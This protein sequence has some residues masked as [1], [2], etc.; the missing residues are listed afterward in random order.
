MAID[1]STGKIAACDSEEVY[2]YRPYGRE[3][4]ALRVN[5][6]PPPVF[7]KS[8]TKSQWSLQC[9]L[10]NQDENS[11]VLALSWGS[12]EEL[13]VGS[14]S[15]R[16][17]QTAD[18]VTMIW[19]RQLSRPAKFAQFSPDANLIASTGLYDRL[20]K[21]WRRQSF[22]ADDTRFD[23]TYLL[24]PKT[25]TSVHWRK[26]QDREQSAD[27]VLY[28]L[29]ADY[30]VRI[31]ATTAPH[32]LQV[33]QLWAEIDM[34]ESVQPRQIQSTSQLNERYAF[35]IDSH[36]FAF[37]TERAMQAASDGN[38]EENHALEHLME[39]AKRNPEVCVVLDGRGN[40]SAWGLESIGCKTKTPAIKFN[41]AH[42][43]NFSLSKLNTGE[44][45]LQFLNFCSKELHSTF[46]LLVHHFDGRIEWLE[47]RV[48]ELFDP[49]PRRNR[50]QSKALWTGHD[51]SVKKIVRNR[52]GTA[53]LS[54]TN[55]NEG[56]LWKQKMSR[57]AMTLTRYSSLSCSEHIHRTCL[58]DEGDFVVNLHHHSVSVWDMRASVATQ[59]A[60]ANFEVEGK[61]LCLL[62]LREPD[63]LSSSFYVAVITSRMR[64]IVW[65]IQLSS[66]NHWDARSEKRSDT[67]I[68]QFCSFDLKVQ[69]DLQFVLPVDPAGSPSVSSSFLDTFA[70]DT[71][72]SYTNSGV[73]CAWAAVIEV[74][75]PFVN[76]VVT[77]R[78]E[79]GI[80]NPSLASGSS[81]RKTAIIDATR[82]GLTI[83]DASSGQLEYD[84]HYGVQDLIQDLDWSSTPDEQSILAVGFPHK[85]VILSQMRFDYINTGPAWAPI[86]QIFI[87]ESTPHPIG[88]S[89]WL[90]NGNLVIGSGNQLYVYDQNVSISDEFITDLSIPVHTHRSMTLFDLVT[91]L[92]GPLPVF[93]PQ[94]LAQCMLAGRLVQ[95]Q[96]I[97]IGLHKALKFFS[98]GDE[99]DSFVSLPIDSFFAE[100]LV[101]SAIS[102]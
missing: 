42:V 51:G 73:L 37:A 21:L 95:V 83:W 45:N 56:L 7:P 14:I 11:E 46:T 25:V 57:S 70:K 39:I 60:F 65:K 41:I 38:S 40:M 97:I 93:H 47:G 24:H 54:R 98:N 96:K 48:D 58:L 88:D 69:E 55:D 92:N 12:D 64:G 78:V 20:I 13:L 10:R 99:L 100:S 86:R 72:I 89:T 90:G 59:A 34:Q 1:E 9:T 76:W 26:P 75:E 29:C 33:L 68:T 82:T 67:T 85:V 80:Q 43:E 31:W 4:G 71:A 66:T 28:S 36:D 84:V 61:L 5:A 8:L 79:T 63:R 23:F 74:E 30:K 44:S 17:F 102:T 53:L 32:G 22:G 27:N 52:S 19:S 6:A 2:I 49:S 16:L 87:K 94:F 77:S 15:L 3:E 62:L 18:E 50:L 91:Y 35:I 81:I 101:S